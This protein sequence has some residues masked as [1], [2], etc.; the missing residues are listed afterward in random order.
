MKEG[1][2]KL[3]MSAEDIGSVKNAIQLLSKL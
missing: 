2:D 1:K 3:S